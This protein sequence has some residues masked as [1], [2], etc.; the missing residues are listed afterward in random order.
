MKGS[1][2]NTLRNAEGVVSGEALSGALGISRVAV[3]KHISKLRKLGYTIQGGPKGYR[4][5]GSPDLLFPWEFPTR[6]DRIH[7]F[8]ETP[9]TMDV[10]RDLARRGCP[11]F[12]VVVAERQWAGRGRLQRMW[13]SAEGGIYATVVLRPA[14]PVTRAPLVGFA[15]AL[16][17]AHTL[18][19]LYRID[20]RVKWPNDILVDGRK[21]CGILSEMEAEADGVRFVN[22]G[23]GINVRNDPSTDEPGATSLCRLVEPTRLSRK[24]VFGQLLDELEKRIHKT[25]LDSVITDWKE[26]T[27]TL[28]QR[29]RI[30]T[31]HDTLAGTALDVDANG[32]LILQTEDGRRH[33]IFYGDC[34][35]ER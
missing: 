8:T 32:G 5:I 16:A 20:A 19:R 31:I 30:A 25:P 18:R 34:F 3:W 21:L 14:F 13:L 10:A 7:Y 12:T 33:T 6:R 17:V 22:I 15:A 23:I 29:V 1:I 2:I 9:S 27:V 4:F 24:E 28:G 11:D 26:L 35:H